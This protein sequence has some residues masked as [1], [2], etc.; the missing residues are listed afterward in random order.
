MGSSS[1]T[2]YSKQLS[3]AAMK[4]SIARFKGP[5]LRLA[6][7]LLVM[8][9]VPATAGA[10][11]LTYYPGGSAASTSNN[12]GD[13]DHHF[14]YAWTITGIPIVPVGQQ[15]TSAFVTFKNMY[16][17]DNTANLLYLDLF[18]T[19]SSG[20]N[21]L[22]SNAGSTGGNAYTSTVRNLQE[23]PL[24][25][26]PAPI[27]PDVYDG[28]N[29]LLSGNNI[30]LT[31]HAF[32]PSG[33]SPGN[34]ADIAWLTNLLTSYSTPLPGADAQFGAANPQWTFAADP[35]GGWDYTYN[36]TQNQVNTLTAYI[37][38]T[39]G[40]AGAISLAFD[41][42]CHFFNDGVSLT[43]NEGAITT[44]SAVPEPASMLLLGT[45]LV[46]LARRYRRKSSAA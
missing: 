28:A 24:N 20:G 17:W 12:L 14:Y 35:T 21:V 26:V 45:G 40:N 15:I 7:A 39:G 33:R 4:F 43:L 46:F 11:V 1:P 22:N 25:Q 8:V 16:N 41:P 37:N 2:S 42:E 13:L 6:L 34:A 44:T 19:I 38:G 31:E 29:G 30:D 32:L 18:G 23:V 3:E 9:T 27:L 5:F 36:F 10:T